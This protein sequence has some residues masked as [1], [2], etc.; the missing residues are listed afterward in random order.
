[1]IEEYPSS[2]REG[3]FALKTDKGDII[4]DDWNQGLWLVDLNCNFKRKN[5]LIQLF[6]NTL[7]KNRQK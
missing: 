2:E 1:M 6:D 4:A 3:K 7:T 5:W